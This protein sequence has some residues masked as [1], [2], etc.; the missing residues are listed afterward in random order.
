RLTGVVIQYHATGWLAAIRYGKGESRS[1][2]TLSLSASRYPQVSAAC[3][4]ICAIMS[5]AGTVMTI[6][7]SSHPAKTRLLTPK[8]RVTGRPSRR[9]AKQRVLHMRFLYFAAAA[10]VALGLPFGVAHASMVSYSQ[11]YVFGD[12]L[13]DVGNI[14]ELTDHNVPVSPPYAQGRFTNGKVWV[15]YL[16]EDLGLGPVT[17]SLNGGNDFAYGAAQTG[18]TIVHKGLDVVDL[19]ALD[20]TAQQVQYQASA[21]A[22]ASDALYTL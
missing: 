3:H 15:Q 21:P 20:L 8:R 17:A 6:C 2:H 22:P 14:Y 11:L 19:P 18:Q 4:I 7:S 1:C 13:S 9:S 10:L 5:M 12:S 16:A